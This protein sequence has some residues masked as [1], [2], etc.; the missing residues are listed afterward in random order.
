[1]VKHLENAC[2]GDTVRYGHH[3][4]WI[5][6]NA[7]DDIEKARLAM[8]HWDRLWWVLEVVDMTGFDGMWKVTPFA[9]LRRYIA[10]R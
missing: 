7:F 3:D 6:E 10:W 2:L 5:F 8:G 1:M 4:D 9:L